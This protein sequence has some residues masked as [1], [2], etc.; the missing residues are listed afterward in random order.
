MEG[1]VCAEAPTVLATGAKEKC[2]GLRAPLLLLARKAEAQ[3]TAATVRA[4]AQRGVAS[5]LEVTAHAWPWRDRPSA[6]PR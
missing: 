1:G 3:F 5:K 2:T 6:K 4:K